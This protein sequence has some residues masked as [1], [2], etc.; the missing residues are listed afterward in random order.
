MVLLPEEHEEEADEDVEEEEEE[1]FDGED[2]VADARCFLLSS[3][4]FN[5]DS[6]RENSIHKEQCYMWLNSYVHIPP[7]FSMYAVA[8]MTSTAIRCFPASVF[9]AVGVAAAA[10]A[11]PLPSTLPRKSPENSARLVHI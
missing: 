2:L 7:L 4:R 8:S 9:G 11:V 3:T 5:K 1:A 6:A 10:A